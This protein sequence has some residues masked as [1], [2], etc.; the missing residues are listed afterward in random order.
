M[1]HHSMRTTCHFTIRPILEQWQGSE[2]ILLRCCRL[3]HVA[4]EQCLTWWRRGQGRSATRYQQEAELK[5]SRAEFP[6]HAA[7]HSHVLQDVLARLDQTYQDYFRRLAAGEHPGFPRFQGGN[8][9]HSLTYKD[10][11]EYGNGARLD[12]GHLILSTIGRIAVR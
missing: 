10:Y 8:R 11:K 9:Y 6:G 3:Y 2:I 5:N 4:L 12:N 7:I 1:E